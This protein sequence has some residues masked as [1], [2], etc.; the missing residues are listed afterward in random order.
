[1][2][3]ACRGR[4]YGD[5][6]RPKSDLHEDAPSRVDGLLSTINPLDAGLTSDEKRLLLAGRERGATAYDR[7]QPPHSTQCRGVSAFKVRQINEY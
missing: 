1:M 4:I 3:G 2:S 5:L 6:Q 7:N